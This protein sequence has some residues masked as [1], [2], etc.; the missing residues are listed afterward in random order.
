MSNYVNYNTDPFAELD[1]IPNDKLISKFQVSESKNESPLFF[2]PDDVS[3]FKEEES[4]RK[5]LLDNLY[6][7]SEEKKK[8]STTDL[9]DSP[10]Y[11]GNNLPTTSDDNTSE[12]NTFEQQSYQKL[13]ATEASTKITNFLLS[14]NLPKHAVA[15]IVGNLYAESK[16]NTSALGDGKTSGGI[17]QW[18]AQRFNNLKQFAKENNKDWR[19]LDIQLEF[20]WHELNTSYAS[21]LNKLKTA[22]S[23]EKAAEIWG[24]DYEVF[25]GHENFNHGRYKERKNYAKQFYKLLS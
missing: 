21:V 15:G 19:D 22:N 17:A 14:K 25:S 20:L 12:D 13:S 9:T 24:H 2:D 16:F 4:Y 1:L 5:K 7:I 10:F 23:T 8:S 6:T 18:H 11:S 3:P